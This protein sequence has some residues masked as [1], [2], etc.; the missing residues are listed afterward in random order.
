M[1]DPKSLADSIVSGKGEDSMEMDDEGG[2]TDLELVAEDILAA[3][4]S[5]DPKALASSLKAFF[6]AADAEP[7]TE[8]G[9][10]ECCPKGCCVNGCGAGGC[11]A[12]CSECHP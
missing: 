2:G 10:K 7:H 4:A 3:C 5:S 11:A 12:G 8:G 9:D 6:L 1:F